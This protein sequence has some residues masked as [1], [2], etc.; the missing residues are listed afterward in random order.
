MGRT[1]EVLGGRPRRTGSAEPVA[2]IPFPQPDPEPETKVELVPV[3]ADDLPPDDDA[4]P[5]IEVGLGMRRA[6]PGPQ[7]LAPKPVAAP[8]VSSVAFQLLPG[9][10]RQR[11]SPADD[12]IAYHR[13]EH[14]TARQYRRLVDGIAAHHTS[15]RAPVL[16]FCPASQRSVGSGTVANLAV[17][18]AGDGFGRVLVVELDRAAGS[19]GTIFDLPP[20]PGLKELLART[21][22]LG[23]VVHRTGVEGLFVLPAGQA[24]VGVD[25]LDRLP[26]VLDQLRARY[27]WILVE[28]PAWGNHPLG[29]WAKASDGVYLI[30]NQ[31]EWD[32]PVTDAAHDGIARAGGRLK[33][34]I[35]TRG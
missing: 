16:V 15:G 18:R 24:D 4:V 13:P 9:A 12:L 35:T 27:D 19:A 5:H 10:A 11:S 6:T 29:D 26:A 33:G 3:G 22:P 17:T 1:F 31:D 28:G 14:P 8:P 32:S 34:C 21:L 25:E 7:L 2:A 23:L 20:A 30:L